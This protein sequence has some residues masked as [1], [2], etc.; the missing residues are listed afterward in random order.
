[1]STEAR[2]SLHYPG[3]PGQTRSV[4]FCIIG[5]HMVEASTGIDAD[6]LP[7]EPGSI[8]RFTDLKVVIIP[9][10]PPHFILSVI[11]AFAVLFLDEYFATDSCLSISRHHQF[12]PRFAELPISKTYLTAL[13]FPAF[14]SFSASLTLSNP[15]LFSN[16]CAFNRPSASKRLKH[17]NHTNPKSFSSPCTEPTIVRL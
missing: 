13:A 11:N 10:S 9:K 2:S 12:K 3:W 14:R 1:V 6:S 8:D 4:R 5:H 17:L 16:G 7:E 15:P